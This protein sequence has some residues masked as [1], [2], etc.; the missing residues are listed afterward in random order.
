MLGLDDNSGIQTCKIYHRLKNLQVSIYV[1]KR[2]LMELLLLENP[3]PQIQRERP[4]LGWGIVGWRT[5]FD[6]FGAK[7]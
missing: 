3:S 6:E 5:K 2:S 1:N 4:D 7:F